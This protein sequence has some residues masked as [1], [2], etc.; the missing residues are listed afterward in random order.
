MMKHFDIFRTLPDA[1]EPIWINA[2]ESVEA[3]KALIE[4]RTKKRPAEYMVFDQR[5]GKRIVFKLDG[6]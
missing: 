2:V 1:S 3:A 5:I 6:H 4:E